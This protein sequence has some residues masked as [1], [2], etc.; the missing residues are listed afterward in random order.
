M[1]NIKSL[2]NSLSPSEQERFV[3]FQKKRNK[4]TDDKNLKLFK[5][6][7]NGATDP[8]TISQKLYGK[9]NKASYHALRNRLLNSLL[10]FI[11]QDVINHDNQEDIYLISRLIAARKLLQNGLYDFGYNILNSIERTA[12]QDYN[13]TILNEVYI[14]AIQHAHNNP[15]VTLEELITQYNNNKVF[16]ELEAQL[17]IIYASI[18]KRLNSLIYTGEHFIFSEVIENHLKTNQLDI[19]D[20][21]F[22]SLYQLIALAELSAETTKN[23][24]HV[25]PFIKSICQVISTHKSAEKEIYY[26]LKISY[27]IANIYFRNKQFQKTLQY[28]DTMFYLMSKHQK[29]Y[30][31][32]FELKYYNLLA[33]THC[34]TKSLNTAIQTATQ[35]LSKKHALTE[36]KLNLNLS[37]VTYHILNEDYR[38]ANKIFQKLRHSDNW[39]LKKTN[40]DWIIKK[41]I[42]ELIIQIEL[43]HTDLVNYK[44]INFKR[45]FFP[46]LK[47]NHRLYIIHFINAIEQFY[48]KEKNI[49]YNN[50]I[51]PYF[52][53]EN[54]IKKDIFIISFY[55][56]LNAKVNK[57]S[58]YNVLTELIYNSSSKKDTQ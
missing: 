49:T 16:C 53:D 48:F 15:K 27:T 33:L 5:L 20:L 32:Q 24:S 6:L 30:F 52:E 37:L 26:H 28:L 38:E 7:T 45:K 42:I 13:Y 3:S 9:T 12:R 4:R 58:T 54:L 8:K 2:I 22:K 1:N 31:K 56:W 29:R 17:N 51:T 47:N 23:Y 57:K 10:D 18:R 34:Y 25:I 36:P 46:Y 41:N 11:A 14:T 43:D 44:L 39:Y 50:T 21:N 19:K 35:Q 55:S 40:H